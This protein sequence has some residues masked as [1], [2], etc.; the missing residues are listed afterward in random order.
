MADYIDLGFMMDLYSD[1]ELE[2]IMWYESEIVYHG[3]VKSLSYFINIQSQLKKG[4]TF[5]LLYN[6][7]KKF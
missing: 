4:K 5:F 1:Y 2:Y 3:I 6:T 7:R